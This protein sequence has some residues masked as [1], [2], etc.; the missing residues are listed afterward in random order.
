VYAAGG[1]SFG[2]T[3]T[4]EG[5]VHEDALPAMP[6]WETANSKKIEVM[7]QNPESHEM[8]RLK[9]GDSPLM[10]GAVTPQPRPVPMRDGS[11]N[12]GYGVGAA[13]GM[14]GQRSP[15]L[16]PDLYGAGATNSAL[17]MNSAHADS[18]SGYRGAAPNLGQLGYDRNQTYASQGYGGGQ[19]NLGG[20][21]AGYGGGGYANDRYQVSPVHEYPSSGGQGYGSGHG[22]GGQ[23]QSYGGGQG[24]GYGRP[25]QGGFRDV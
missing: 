19:P 24:G 8:D 14:G 15:R 25:N 11:D 22:G 10:S 16:P 9:G 7:E 20:S 23:Y 4:F 12:S 6:S 13:G 18:H 21:G 5:K 17:S 2:Q 3:A 1:D